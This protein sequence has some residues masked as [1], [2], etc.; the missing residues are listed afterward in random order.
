MTRA[1]LGK[2]NKSSI[3][4]AF[5]LSSKHG[6]Q[7]DVLLP[8]LQSAVPLTPESLVVFKVTTLKTLAKLYGLKTS[9]TKAQLIEK[10][11][12][13][14]STSALVEKS[15]STKKKK[16]TQISTK[17]EIKQEQ[18]TFPGSGTIYSYEYF[19]FHASYEKDTNFLN[20]LCRGTLPLR[21]QTN[22]SCSS[23]HLQFHHECMKL[24][25]QQHKTNDFL[26]PRCQFDK[27]DPFYPLKKILWMSYLDPCLPQTS[28]PTSEGFHTF[29]TTFHLDKLDTLR[30]Y[31]QHIIVQCIRLGSTTA[32]KYLQH[33]WPYSIT[34]KINDHI[35]SVLPPRVDH[36]RRDNPLFLTPYFNSL[37]NFI[38]IV[39]I[40]MFTWKENSSSFALAFLVCDMLPM[41]QLVR[42]IRE[43]PDTSYETALKRVLSLISPVE[44]D[45]D[46]V[47]CVEKV[48]KFKLTCPITLTRLV[49]P[50]RGKHC[51]HLQCFDLQ[52]FLDI[53]KKSKVFNSRWKCPECSLIVRPDTLV[54]DAFVSF[55]LNETKHL[56]GNTVEISPDGTWKL[57]P[58]NAMDQHTCVT[59]SDDSFEDT[60]QKTTFLM[61]ENSFLSGNILG[62]TSL[63]P[64]TVDDTDA[65]EETPVNEFLIVDDR[66]TL[67]TPSHEETTQHST[68]NQNFQFNHP[69]FTV[70]HGKDLIDV[71]ST[72]TDNE[73][74]THLQFFQMAKKLNDSFHPPNHLF[75]KKKRDNHFTVTQY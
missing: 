26:C 1:E 33:E 64:I 2:R 27:M 73:D 6:N 68:K 55:I 49:I 37:K 52:S 8:F 56:Q 32:S 3:Q 38:E 48:F 47:L 62:D 42:Q 71:S 24:I 10:L 28:S 60:L 20:C 40:D 19:P 50:S 43:S 21:S 51:K 61:E 15:V 63:N 29:S 59:D 31:D 58:L 25:L 9:G 22:I 39:V 17:K 11:V 75:S 23:C 41:F 54:E 57:L 7:D 72:S 69:F 30:L 34:I 36:K 74:A 12:K 16:S 70:Q 4:N 13:I 45:E 44:K 5:N 18:E 53:T 35:E 46:D 66:T 65:E 14:G 67:K